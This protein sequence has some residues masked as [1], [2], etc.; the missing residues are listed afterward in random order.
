[1]PCKT[2]DLLV[3]NSAGI[4][5]I[6]RILAGP[7][8]P[9]QLMPFGGSLLVDVRWASLVSIPAGGLTIPVAVP[10][11]AALC[12]VTFALQ[13]L[14]QDPGASHGVAFSPGLELVLGS[15]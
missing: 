15:A 11:D 12:G 8:S 14:Q 1:V 2:I 6:G 7:R 4:D 13:T 3:G 10:C 5:T 9:P